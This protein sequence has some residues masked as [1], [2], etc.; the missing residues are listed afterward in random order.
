M[1][2]VTAPVLHM[3]HSELNEQLEVVSEI[4]VAEPGKLV[5]DFIDFGTDIFFVEKRQ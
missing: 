2:G 4:Q 5:E 3:G 1:S